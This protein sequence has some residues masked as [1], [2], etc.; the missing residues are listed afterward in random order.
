MEFLLKLLKEHGF[1]EVMVNV[2]HLAEEIENSSAMAS[3]SALKL[4]TL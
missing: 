4:P 3:A 1:T 2:S